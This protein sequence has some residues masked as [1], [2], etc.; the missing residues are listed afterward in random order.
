MPSAYLDPSEYA[1]YGV[2]DASLSDVYS[3]STQIDAYLKRP[4]GLLWAPDATGLPAYMAG[5]NPSATYPLPVAITPGVNVKIA[6]P[7]VSAGMADLIGEVFVIDRANLLLCEAVTV[8]GTDTQLGTITLSRVRFAHDQGA[9]MD[10]GMQILEEREL[11]A[12]RSIARVSRPQI[13]RLLSGLGRYSYGR[14]SDQVSGIFGDINLL[15]AIQTFGG[16]PAWMPFDAG[17]T[18]I[19][20]ATNEVWIPAGQL[21][22]Y[23]SEVRLRYV[24]GFA[25]SAVPE[26]IKRATAAII[27]FA[28]NYPDVPGSFKTFQAGGTKIER[29]S[30]SVFDADTR[31][32]LEP[33]RLKLFF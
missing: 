1:A 30:D 17:N 3:A 33:Y 13:V 4:E 31:S 23:F 20:A 14:R 18:S 25:A 29:F 32:Q 28:A 16:S 19:S 9:P 26:G 24:A 8:I 12:K 27:G 15:A 22:A 6:F 2:P 5:M 10:A 21:I 7:A 11:P